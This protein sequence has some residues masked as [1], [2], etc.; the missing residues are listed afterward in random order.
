M[1][2][3]HPQTQTTFL[4]NGLAILT[5]ETC[6]IS[7]T[8][9]AEFELSLTHQISKKTK[10]LIVG[11]IIQAPTP[12]GL[13]VFRIYE[14]S[15][16][17]EDYTTIKASHIFF[18][19]IK[20]ANIKIKKQKVDCNTAIQQILSTTVKT[21]GFKGSSNITISEN[22]EFENI[23]TLKA[24]NDISDIFKGEIIKDNFNFTINSPLGID[25]GFFIR[26]GKNLQGL[27]K[28]VNY[29]SSFNIVIPIASWDMDFIYLPE[30]FYSRQKPDE[31]PKIL[32]VIYND[33]RDDPDTIY[34]ADQIPPIL[35][36]RAK[37]LFDVD[38]INEPEIILTVNFSLIS[39][40]VGFEW[41][42]P[43][44][45]ILIGDLVTVEYP[46]LNIDLKMRC[47]NYT[48]DAI[49]SKYLEI[50]IGGLPKKFTSTVNTN[51]S[52]INTTIG[53]ISV[54]GGGDSTNVDLAPIIK[55]LEKIW[56]AIRELQKAEAFYPKIMS[57]YTH[58]QLKKFTNEELE[59][60][61]LGRS[62]L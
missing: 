48:Y 39:D 15:E 23:N 27:T 4:T 8:L 26:Y 22:I 38:K 13:Q 2:T 61:Y 16:D 35:R 5:P 20:N 33:F 1:I 32:I 53:D 62:P 50:E 41:Y 51:V 18:D 52:N 43:L 56:E 58:E 29:D 40:K 12:N 46:P 25:R 7:E 30:V 9:N 28:E 10:D 55:E 44:E 59:K 21:H 17:I 19:L 31:T 57:L 14:T 34:Y 24:I 11:N 6:L 54:S 45:E 60:W 47:Y 3:L 49:N 42:K 36:Q 37:D